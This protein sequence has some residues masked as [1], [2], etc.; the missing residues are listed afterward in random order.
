MSSLQP[1]DEW[2]QR[3]KE[4][5]EQVYLQ[6]FEELRRSGKDAEEAYEIAKQL[7]N[8]VGLVIES[9]T[10]LHGVILYLNE[11]E[12][13]PGYEQYEDSNDG[14]SNSDGSSS[15]SGDERECHVIPLK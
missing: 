14:G 1:T 4:I 6:S 11:A 8:A 13:D 2:K 3:T 5:V 10:A 9:K 12:L 7:S 15:S